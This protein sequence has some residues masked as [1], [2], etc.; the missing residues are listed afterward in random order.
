MAKNHKGGFWTE[1]GVWA[2]TILTLALTC[3]ALAMIISQNTELRRENE[4]L[5]L[6]VRLF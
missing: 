1:T 3:T 2:V 5:L 4:E 6:Q